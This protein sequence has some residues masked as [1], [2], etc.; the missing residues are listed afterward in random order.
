MYGLVDSGASDT[1]IPYDLMSFLG[2]SEANCQIEPCETAGGPTD[3]YVWPPGIE[4]NVQQM[5]RKV[6][7][8]ASFTKGLPPRV[9][10]L[11]RKDFFGQFRV[12][13][14][15]RAQTFSLDPYD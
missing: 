12:E 11:G 4:V 2:I 3:Q 10:L 15:E 13:I 7:V 5:A 6:A 14:D 9:V 8:K 1:L